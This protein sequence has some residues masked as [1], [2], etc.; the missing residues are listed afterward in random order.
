MNPRVLAITNMYPSADRPWQ[1]TFVE[2]QVQGLM[3]IG[4]ETNVLYFDRKTEGPLIYYRMARR[5]QTAL[6][7]FEP[8]LIHVM[9]GG[10][11]AD[12]IT[13]LPRARPVIVTFH[14][15]DLLGENLSGMWRKLVSHHGVRCSWLA[16]RRAQ[17]VVVVARHLERVL[18]A[19]VD[20]RKVRVIPCGID[21][22]RFQPMNKDDCRQ[23]LG[24][25]PKT[26]H[27]LF[28]AN[29][30]DPVKRPWLARAAVETL[31]AQGVQAELHLLAG[32]PYAEV[33]WWINACDVLILTSLHEGSPTVVKEALA[34]Q[35]PVVSVEVG[36]VAERIAGVEGCHLAAAEPHALARKLLAVRNRNARVHAGAAVAALSLTQVAE[37]LKG[38]YDEV[39]DGR[40]HGMTPQEAE[41]IPV[42]KL[43]Q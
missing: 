4:V 23:K 42:E 39:L 6:A 19:E 40:V 41:R 28:P 32:V 8:H 24:W 31:Q 20:R 13:D 38:F 36:D 3:S 16:A 43:S 21:L 10:V 14:G 22:E 35:V 37:R 25:T 30:G 29:V 34:C 12:K 5:I 26:F 15:S 11:M 1:G 18:P 33:P 17:G 9:Y 27:V 7:S 2:Q